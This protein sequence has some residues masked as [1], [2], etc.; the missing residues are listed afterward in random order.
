MSGSTSFLL[1]IEGA[2]LPVRIGCEDYEIRRMERTFEVDLR[3]GSGECF[4]EFV[5]VLGYIVTKPGDSEKGEV[6][7]LAGGTDVGEPGGG[8]KA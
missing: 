6:L 4:A 8:A 1:F 7:R 5:R 2:S 3:D